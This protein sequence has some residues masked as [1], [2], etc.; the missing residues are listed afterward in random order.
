MAR[1]T[2][3]DAAFR[4]AAR[5]LGDARAYP[6]A[7]WLAELLEVPRDRADRFLSELP[8]LEP[9]DRALQAAHRTGGRRLYAQIRAPFELYALVRALRPEH[10]VETGVSS[11]VSSAHF[12]AALRSN[13]R[14]RLHSIDLPL[15]QRGTR[16]GSR[17]SPVSL[18]PG[19]ASGWAVPR[20]LTRGWDLRIGPSSELLPAL[21][22][23]LPRVDLF[24]HDSRHTPAHLT[25]ELETIRPKLRP[26]SIVLADNTVWTGDAFPR[27]ARSLG[28]R[29]RRRGRSDLVGLRVPATARGAPTAG[30]AARRRGG[31][32]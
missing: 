20:S 13:R 10:V 17:E 8:R 5:A 31:G 15:H 16:L 9:L 28:A 11:G 2:R 14:G 4:A 23:E 19:R 25:F 22:A 3:A 7:R 21:L 30:E 6:N 27:F 29:V 24:L 32:G 1:S 18:P 26:G 12:L